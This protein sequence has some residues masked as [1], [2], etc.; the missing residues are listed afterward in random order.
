MSQQPYTNDWGSGAIL[1]MVTCSQNLHCVCPKQLVLIWKTMTT[2][3]T[4]LMLTGV[5]TV[6][7]PVLADWTRDR[8]FALNSKYACM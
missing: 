1:I 7:I 4:V 3:A 8:H 6:N 5:S 2:V